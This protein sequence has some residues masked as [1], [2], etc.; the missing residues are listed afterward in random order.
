[1]EFLYNKQRGQALAAAKK[2][3]GDRPF[4]DVEM[5]RDNFETILRHL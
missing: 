3:E 4:R 1:M 2:R 5:A